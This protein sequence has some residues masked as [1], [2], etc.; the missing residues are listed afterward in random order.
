MKGWIS[1]NRQIQ[2]HWLYSEKRIF[3]KYEAWI[4]MLFMASHSE[5]KFIHGNNLLIQKEGEFITSELKLMG[6]WQWGKSKTRAFLQLLQN[7]KMIDKKTDHKKTTV[8]ILNYN[9]YQNHKPQNIPVSDQ[10]QTSNRPVTD[11]INND[12]KENK[13][14]KQSLEIK[15]SDA[16]FQNDEDKTP[17]SVKGKKSKTPREISDASVEEN[18]QIGDIIKT[19][20]EKI[21][22]LLRYDHPPE[23]SAC[24]RL[25]RGVGAEE[26]QKALN[27][28]ITIKDGRYVKTITTP[29]EFEK[30]FAWIGQYSLKINNQ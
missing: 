20:K 13:E 12:N 5:H 22:P 1:L 23:R 10:C 25:L 19:F 30:N 3:S 4:D 11:T 29:R 24:L 27:Y 28:Y 7:E 9:K 17:S 8:F 21:N 18:K 2:Q 14:N 15:I 16:G 6:K 26:A